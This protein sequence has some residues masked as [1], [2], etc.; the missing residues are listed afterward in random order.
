VSFPDYSR[1][2]IRDPAVAAGTR[3]GARCLFNFLPQRPRSPR[4]APDGFGSWR[5]NSGNCARGNEKLAD[6]K[7]GRQWQ[8]PPRGEGSRRP[9]LFGSYG[10]YETEGAEKK[11]RG[12]VR[13]TAT[14]MRRFNARRGAR[15]LC[16]H[17]CGEGARIPRRFA[18]GLGE[19]SNWERARNV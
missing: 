4:M 14:R 18:A 6:A 5:N 12:E 1:I 3:R 10:N 11:P 19:D 15:R 2:R 13:G 16:R 9:P 8:T 17:F 7:E